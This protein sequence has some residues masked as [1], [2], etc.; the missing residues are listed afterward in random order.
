MLFKPFELEPGS[1]VLF[2]VIVGTLI[3]TKMKAYRDIFSQLYIVETR[4]SGVFLKRFVLGIS[5]CMMLAYSM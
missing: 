1:S 2:S 4:A 3:T 5:L